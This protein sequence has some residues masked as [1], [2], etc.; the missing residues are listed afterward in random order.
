M[1]PYWDGQVYLLMT[2]VRLPIMLPKSSISVA[3]TSL[4]IWAQ[5]PTANT[6]SGR[7]ILGA[8]K[9]D[10]RRNPVHTTLVPLQF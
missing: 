10:A 1:K 4:A 9:F 7:K 8:L 2:I 6:N 3:H 5:G